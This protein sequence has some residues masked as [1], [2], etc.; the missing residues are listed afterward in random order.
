MLELA[1]LGRQR[2]RRARGDGGFVDS[3]SSNRANA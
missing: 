1:A 2:A 3:S